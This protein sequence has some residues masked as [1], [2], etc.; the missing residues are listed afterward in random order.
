MGRKRA[1]I[2]GGSLGGL[3][4]AHL[5]RAIE[6]DVAVFE[7]NTGDLAGR[8]AGIGTHDA[9]LE[10]AR[11]IG[12]RLDGVHGVET[13]AY[14]CLDRDGDVLGEVPLRRVM[15]AWN[16]IYRP[17]KDT[18]PHESYHHGRTLARVDADGD[19]VIA[20]FV[21][22]TRA[23]GDLLIAADGF[24]STVREQFLPG[25]QPSYAGYV[26]WRAL[27]PESDIPRALRASLLDR[28]TFCIPS[29]ELAVSY[30]VPALDGD[31]S[32]GHRAYN[33]VWYRPADSKTLAA[34]STDVD[35]HRHDAAI[36]PAL[37]RPE[38]LSA[39]KADAE[40]LL[41]PS[42]AAVFKH[43]ERPFFHPIYDLASP[44]LTFGRVVL[45]GDAAFVARP[46]VGA[47]V[48][49]AGLDAACL[50]DALAGDDLDR[51]LAHYSTER[52][53]FGD[54]I[55]ARGRVMGAS[56]GKPGANDNTRDPLA[57]MRQYVSMAHDLRGLPVNRV[58]R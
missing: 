25:A 26:A 37:I 51:A 49:K 57:I 20:I 32:E 18:L 8:G 52:R 35:G 47:G 24:R 54:W 4:A 42:V 56:I 28:M 46:H 7:R 10:V 50:A 14:A 31:T 58:G 39:I 33:V 30:P 34:L 45:L 5:L 13:Q 11:R 1:L 55:V 38:V 40:R 3:F 17:L 22:G 23:S 43:A 44:E 21:D 48:T 6:W 16:V 53:R 9:L 41:A 15:S 27:I 29:G 19:R 2:I 12:V 36:P